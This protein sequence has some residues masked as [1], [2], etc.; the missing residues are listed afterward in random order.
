MQVLNKQVCS[1]LNDRVTHDLDDQVNSCDCPAGTAAFI[2]KM[3]ALIDLL[4]SR[5]PF[6]HNDSRLSDLLTLM[7]WLTTDWEA[8]V[9][10]AAARLGIADKDAVRMLPAPLTRWVL[11]LTIR[12]LVGLVNTFHAMFPS[13][14]ANG[15]G[16]I[17]PWVT[18][19]CL[20]NFFS[21]VRSTGG[22]RNFTMLSFRQRFQII[23]ESKAAA[24]STKANANETSF[25]PMLRSK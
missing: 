11:Q 5:I 12:R 6:A 18:Q 16:L 4:D 20:E 24:I 10:D 14:G 23:F 3:A 1:A 22:S 9:L 7:A 13:V 17:I 19:D 15:R 8:E 21:L 2:G 25:I